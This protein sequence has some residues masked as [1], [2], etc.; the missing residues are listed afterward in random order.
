[1]PAPP[2]GVPPGRRPATPWRPSPPS[3][4][5][6]VPS[7]PSGGSAPSP[8]PARA[9]IWA[10]ASAPTGSAALTE[11]QPVRR[12]S[13]SSLT[14]R[15]VCSAA[16]HVRPAFAVG[17]P[18]RHGPRSAARP[19]RGVV[20]VIAAPSRPWLSR[21]R[22]DGRR[23]R[24]RLQQV[25]GHRVNRG[26]I[27]GCRDVVR[28]GKSV[29]LTNAGPVPGLVGLSASGRVRP[30]R[31]RAG[32]LVRPAGQRGRPGG[33]P[34]GLDVGVRS[35]APSPA[36]PSR[37]LST[38][39]LSRRNFR[40]GRARSS[41]ATSSWPAVSERCSPDTGSRPSSST[42]RLQRLLERHAVP[43]ALGQRAG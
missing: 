35:A 37:P 2:A 26:S 27:A 16:R 33:L 30:G 17:P 8:L 5:R 22:P 6:P 40:R 7:G 9:P 36:S 24:P 41:T 20:A 42:A 14:G 11:Q 39:P 18:C 12:C 3:P 43:V 25:S 1:M 34:H 31:R 29:H 28:D 23:S 38:G 10:P 19:G 32:R 21:L 4:R 13:G 15:Y